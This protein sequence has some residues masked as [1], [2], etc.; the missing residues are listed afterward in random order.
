MGNEVNMIS[1]EII[2]EI[3]RDA[4][5][6]PS[7]DNTQPWRFFVRNNVIRVSNVPEKDT[8]LFNWHQMSNHVALG[9]CLENLRVSAEGHGFHT[10]IRLFPNLADRLIVAEMRLT[11]ST[12]AMNPLAPYIAERTTNRRKYHAKRIETNKLL[13][14]SRLNS[15]IGGRIVFITEQTKIKELACIV[16]MGEK[17]ALEDKLIHDFLFNHVTW[18]KEEDEMKH[19]FFIETFEFTSPQRKVFQIFQNW[20][21][22]KFF[23]PFGISNIIARDMRKVHA[24]SAAFGAIIVPDDAPE[25]FLRAGILLERIWLTVTKLK[26]SLQPVTTVHFIGTRVLAGDPGGLSRVHQE[27]LRQNYAALAC[28]FNVNETERFGFV[29]RL[30]YADPPSAMTT[31]V[32]PDIT[33]ED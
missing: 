5:R 8:S 9:A 27:L 32:E 4:C 2:F 16:S 21:I 31:R 24:T 7:G 12:S 13:E 20:N 33:F 17:L 6:A 22:L 28:Q 10:D 26:L 3:L 15:D 29:F 19:G 18:S 30:G 25:N 1:R 14:L 11:P 23:L